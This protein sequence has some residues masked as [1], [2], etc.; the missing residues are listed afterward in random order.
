MGHKSKR[1]LHIYKKL[2]SKQRVNVKNLSEFFNTNE[3]T[4][5]RD[6]EDINAFL[7]NYNQTVLYEKSTHDYYIAHKNKKHSNTDINI[8]ATYEMTYQVFKQ[9]NR[10]Y[11]TYVV[12]KTRKTIIV[13]LSISKIEAINLCFI[14]HNTIR[15]MS[16]ETLVAEFTQE[17]AKLQNNY[18]L[19]KI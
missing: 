1:I 8:H 5:Q 12:K 19:N 18:I 10:Q 7:K 14:Y 2:L 3:R 6:I 4:I 15:I 13:I 17:L 9:L 16:P 11:E